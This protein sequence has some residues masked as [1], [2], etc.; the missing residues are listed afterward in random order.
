MNAAFDARQFRDAVGW[1]TTGVTVITTRA[2][3]GAPVGITANSFSS[4]SL[5]P[6]LVQF[7]LD[8]RALSLPA[9][10]SFG[11]FAVSILA[12]DQ[13]GLSSRFAKPGGDK[14]RDIDFEVWGSGCPVLRGV[15]AALDCRTEAVHEGGDHLVFIGRVL[16]L[17]ARRHG[18]PLLFS[19]GAYHALGD[20]LG[21]ADTPMQRLRAGGEEAVLSGLEPWFAA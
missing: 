7:G 2:A 12:E 17:E 19:R 18:R 4:V 15:L 20:R 11:H 21:I 3:S 8:R 13:Q 16:R 9:F 1:F 6:P 14:W 10:R 5:D